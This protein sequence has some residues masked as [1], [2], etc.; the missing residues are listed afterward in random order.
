[1]SDTINPAKNPREIGGIGARPPR[2]VWGRWPWV[3]FGGVQRESRI[4]APIPLNGPSASA[5]QVRR[6]HKAWRSAQ[7]G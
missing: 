7:R 6:N 3:N 4:T 1:M 5:D 2:R